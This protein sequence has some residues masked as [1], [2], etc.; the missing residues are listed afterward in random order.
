MC[1]AVFDDKQPTVRKCPFESCIDHF[2]DVTDFRH[3]RAQQ[4]HIPLLERFAHNSVIGVGE[5]VC[6]DI[7][8]C[9]KIHT[10]THQKTDE[11]RDGHGR[12]CIVELHSNKLRQT[13]IV[14]AMR[15]FVV[16]QDVLQGSAGKNVLLLDAQ[17]LSFPGGIVWIQDARNI[18][19][20]I[21][22]LERLGIILRVERIEVQL[23]LGLTLPQTQ[24]TY[25]VGTIAN[26]RHV[27][28]NCVDGLVCKPYLHGQFIAPVA[29]GIAIFRPVVGIFPLTAILKALLE[30]AKA[31][32]QAIT[33][34]RQI[35][36][37]CAVKEAR[38]K[39]SKATIAERCV[40][41]LLQA[42]KIDALFQKS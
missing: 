34:Q 42:G 16:A 33:R 6:G 30:Q 17:A 40:L 14:A 3:D 1:R 39:T 10:L 24:R 22:G 38:S 27:I 8:R 18:L 5:Y 37:R 32:T 21:L 4:L 23:L 28:W 29:P 9:L 7:K 11:F 19:G 26:N 35:A 13:V 36:C 41:D 15:S 25:S 2:D 12:V 31:V 20:F